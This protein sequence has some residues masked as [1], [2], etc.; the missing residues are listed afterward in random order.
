MNDRLVDL[1]QLEQGLSQIVPGTGRILD[2]QAFA[3]ET[4]CLGVFAAGYKRFANR[5]PRFRRD[6]T[7]FNQPIVDRE[8][9]FAPTDGAKDL[10]KRL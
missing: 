6:I 5:V 7:Q 4:D 2:G 1:A 9:L 10:G 3:K 8:R